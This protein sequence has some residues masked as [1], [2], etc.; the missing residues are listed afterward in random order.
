MGIP[1]LRANL[2]QHWDKKGAQQSFCMST[3]TK[4]VVSLLKLP[5]HGNLYGIELTKVMSKRFVRQLIGSW[6]G[7]AYLEIPS[8]RMLPDHVAIAPRLSDLQEKRMKSLQL[9]RKK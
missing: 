2:N 7:K 4:A 8:R 9:P 5:S 3:M 6:S 1:T